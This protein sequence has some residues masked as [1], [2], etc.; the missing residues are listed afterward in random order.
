MKGGE[1]MTE[2]PV[3]T[4]DGVKA[5]D[6]VWASDGCIAELGNQSCF[7][8]CPEICVEVLSPKNTKAEIDEKIAL[9]FEAGAQEAWVCGRRGIMTLYGPARVPLDGSKLCPLFPTQIEVYWGK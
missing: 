6:A 5:A 2:C 7:T 4:V 9:Y 3:S 1:A 8:R